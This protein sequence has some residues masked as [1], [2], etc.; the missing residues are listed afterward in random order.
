MICK[1]NDVKTSSCISSI[2]ELLV[3]NTATNC[4][5]VRF[6]FG[7]GVSVRGVDNSWESVSSGEIKSYEAA[8]IT[9]TYITAQSGTSAT[10]SP[11]ATW[12]IGMERLLKKGNSITFTFQGNQ[13]LNTV[14]KSTVNYTVANNNYTH[15]FVNRGSFV[16]FV[17]AYNFSPFGTRKAANQLQNIVK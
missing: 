10:I 4:S 11:A 7:A 14:S 1:N 12:M 5:N 16:N 15:T 2:P 8:N 13:G 17:L 9:D 3:L 6:I